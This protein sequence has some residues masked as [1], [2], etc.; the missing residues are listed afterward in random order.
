MSLFGFVQMIGT[1]KERKVAHFDSKDKTWWVDTAA[2]NDSDK[3]FETAVKHPRYN[4]GGMVIVELYDTKELAQQGHDNWV[5]IMSS[6]RLPK[7]LLD[8]TTCDIAK[9]I[10]AL[11]DDEKWRSKKKQRNSGAK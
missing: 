2:V 8:V 4:G 3:P 10:A 6:K 1:Y 5:K 7:E 9:L 11:G